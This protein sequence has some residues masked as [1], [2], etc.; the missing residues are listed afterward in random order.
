MR[1]RSG[2]HKR[3]LEPRHIVR[4]IPVVLGR[5][6]DHPRVAPVGAPQR[7]LRERGVVPVASSAWS[8]GVVVML[9]GECGPQGQD[10]AA[11]QQAL[12]RG[13]HI[14]A[15]CIDSFGMLR[16]AAV[17]VLRGDARCDEP[18]GAAATAPEKAR[19]YDAAQ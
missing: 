7:E 10:E 4:S 3:V 2:N 12:S 16:R 6:A 17:P 8:E 14:E 5:A 15:S 1:E 11:G 9:A 13:A 19:P 18:G